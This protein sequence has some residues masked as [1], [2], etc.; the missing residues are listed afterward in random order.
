MANEI[1]GKVI[2]IVDDYTII[3]NLGK[4]NGIKS[5]D[6]FVVYEEGYNVKDP[7]SE[8]TLGRVD[9]DKVE[10]SI[11]KL[12]DK[13]SVCKKFSENPNVYSSISQLIS[14]GSNNVNKAVKLNVNETQ[15]KL[16]SI[17]NPE[18]S[19]GDLVRVNKY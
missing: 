4:E 15:N 7:F 11:H 14:S 18:V 13:F 9:F 1:I 17:K 3:I 19:I 10:V 5:K 16:L 8:E 12:F 6:K 2:E